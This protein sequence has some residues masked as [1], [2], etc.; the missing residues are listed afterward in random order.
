MNQQKLIGLIDA[1]KQSRDSLRNNQNLG[2]LVKS[3]MITSVIVSVVMAIWITLYMVSIFV[4]IS[5]VSHNYYDGK[6]KDTSSYTKSVL[7]DS[8]M[9]LLPM[10]DSNEP[11]S[12]STINPFEGAPAYKYN[13]M[14]NEPNYNYKRVVTK[15]TSMPTVPDTK[16]IVLALG[17]WLVICILMALYGTFIS[18]VGIK[19]ALDISQNSPEAI[20]ALLKGSFKVTPKLLALVTLKTLIVGLGYLLFIIPGIILQIK[21]MFSEIIMLQE[22]KGI[23]ESMKDSMELVKGYKTN[24]YLKQLGLMFLGT[25]VIAPVM[26]LL[27]YPMGMLLSVTTLALY[28]LVAINIYNDLKRIKTTP[29]VV[30]LA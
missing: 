3:A 20:K 26:W 25:F 13:D 2:F 24:L 18:A 10:L 30:P 21:L 14:V 6:T 5:K 12:N 11:G 1:L 29:V 22:N 17:L 15:P 27:F 23:M 28:R 7:G 8:T 16:E 19:T 4:A 9:A